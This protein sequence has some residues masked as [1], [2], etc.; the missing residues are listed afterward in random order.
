MG[1]VQGMRRTTP[2]QQVG[3]P[4]GA[5]SQGM[6]AP[7]VATRKKSGMEDVQNAQNCPSE[8]DG[9]YCM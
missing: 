5:T 8:K 3:K 7:L 9:F 1:E 2:T 6:W 4:H